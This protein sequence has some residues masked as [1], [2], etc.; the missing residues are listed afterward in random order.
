MLLMFVYE[1]MFNKDWRKKKK[2]LHFQ[3]KK[4][5]GLWEKLIEYL[6]LFF[7]IL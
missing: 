6:L 4:P 3:I 1:P 7:L 2:D 5:D